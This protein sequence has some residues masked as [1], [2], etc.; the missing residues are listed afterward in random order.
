MMTRGVLKTS[1]VRISAGETDAVY[2]S[3]GEV[4][5]GLRRRLLRSTSSLNSA[6]ILIADQRGRQELVRAIQKLSFERRSVRPPAA[7]WKAPRAVKAALASLLGAATLL[8]TWFLF[9]H[10]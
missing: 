3:V 9:V 7:D 8:G 2:G 10:R 4:P 5:A 1:T 6:T